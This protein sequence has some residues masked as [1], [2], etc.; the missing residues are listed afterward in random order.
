MAATRIYAADQDQPWNDQVVKI[1]EVTDYNIDLDP[2]ST[3][4]HADGVSIIHLPKIIEKVIENGFPIKSLR[5]K[6]S[7]RSDRDCFDFRF[8]VEDFQWLC[9]CY[10][11]GETMVI[12]YMREEEDWDWEWDPHWS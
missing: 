2:T 12:S 5:R 11:E 1:E 9:S 6:T 7:T 10:I 3:S 8:E 4:V